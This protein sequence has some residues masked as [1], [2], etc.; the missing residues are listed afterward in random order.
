MFNLENI[1][2]TE[3]TV[4]TVTNR[5]SFVTSSF[6]HLHLDSLK[7]SN[8]LIVLKHLNMLDALPS[9]DTM[10]KLDNKMIRSYRAYSRTIVSH[11]FK[12]ATIDKIDHCFVNPSCN[13]K[14]MNYDLTSIDNSQLDCVH[15]TSHSYN[16]VNVLFCALC[17]S[18]HVHPVSF[19]YQT[20]YAKIDNVALIST[21]CSFSQLLQCFNVNTND[22]TLLINILTDIIYLS[23]SCH[24]MLNLDN[25]TCT[26]IATYLLTP[27]S[28]R[29]N[30]ADTVKP[31]KKRKTK[32]R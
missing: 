3:S 14:F 17:V 28:Q 1:L 24:K 16:F 27:P 25:E 20:K 23:I 9:N 10:S 15:S 2:N 30:I 18:H 8:I 6:D 7:I 4:K 11:T 32:K 29:E 12:N 26:K 31:A 21:K 19:A 13:R 5:E 22:V